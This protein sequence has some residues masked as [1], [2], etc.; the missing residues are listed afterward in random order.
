MNKIHTSRDV[1]LAL[2]PAVQ[3]ADY[4]ALPSFS[5]GSTLSRL[6]ELR[7]VAAHNAVVF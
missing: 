3:E 4:G 7:Q 1:V 2:I 6:T 5:C